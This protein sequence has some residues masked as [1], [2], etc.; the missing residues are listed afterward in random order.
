M[1]NKKEIIKNYKNQKQPA[2]IFA[3]KNLVDNKIFIGTSLNLPAKLRGISFELELGSHAFK[4]LADDYKKLGKNNF[5]I[6]ILDELQ[7]KDETDAGL[8]AELDMLESMWV[9]KLK[10]DGVV[11]YNKK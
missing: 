8:R 2:G 11:F 5:E 3:V 6:S 9:E 7:V 4:N 1:I 10:A